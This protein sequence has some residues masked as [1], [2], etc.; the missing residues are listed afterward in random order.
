M[1]KTTRPGPGLMAIDE[2]IQAA[3]AWEATTQHKCQF[4]MAEI[5]WWATQNRLSSIENQYVT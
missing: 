5:N 1:G 3:S 2:V 4:K